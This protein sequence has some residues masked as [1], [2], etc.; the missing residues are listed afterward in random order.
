MHRLAADEAAPTGPRFCL[1]ELRGTLWCNVRPR[2]S[3]SSNSSHFLD[4]A[5]KAPWGPLSMT[6]SA[7]HVRCHFCFI[8]VATLMVF[9]GSPRRRKPLW[10]AVEA[11]PLLCAADVVVAGPLG[12]NYAWSVS[13][14]GGLP[15]QVYHWRQVRSL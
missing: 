12:P 8:P 10:P 5:P 13:C 4:L 2:A 6:T 15:Y 9:A 11:V 7:P 1:R 3:M 14:L